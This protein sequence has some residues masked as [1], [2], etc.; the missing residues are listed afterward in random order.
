MINPKAM[1]EEILDLQNDAY[2]K[3]AQLYPGADPHVLLSQVWLSRKAASRKINP[4]DA[5]AHQMAFFET[6]QFSV[7]PW[8]GNVMALSLYFVSEEL[9]SIAIALPKL[10][11]TFNNLLDPGVSA[12]ASG[13][14]FKMYEEMNPNM[15][16]QHD[17]NTG[18]GWLFT[19]NAT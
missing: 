8:P 9:P 13:D 16:Y 14:Y 4:S 10:K 17:N 15:R 12:M 11:D 5:S 3:A 2:N 7:I 1:V 19:R 6:W 18:T